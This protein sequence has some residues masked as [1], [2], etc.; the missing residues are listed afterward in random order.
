MLGPGPP[1]TISCTW[2][3]NL[4]NPLHA[5]G[6]IIVCGVPLGASLTPHVTVQCAATGALHVQVMECSW[7]LLP[8]TI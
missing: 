2:V 3:V 1:H 7:A 4:A 6:F 8:T 5:F